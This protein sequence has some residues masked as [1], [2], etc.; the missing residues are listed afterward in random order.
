MRNDD[1]VLAAVCR[2]LRPTEK[3]LDL[4]EDMNFTLGMHYQPRTRDDASCFI[5]KHMDDY[6]MMSS[7]DSEDV[8]FDP[9]VL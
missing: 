1:K 2:P 4:I 3:Q 7:L 9:T 8:W 5:N 6:I